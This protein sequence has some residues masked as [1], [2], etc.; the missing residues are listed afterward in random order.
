[1]VDA[2]VQ[3]TL[4]IVCERT[5]RES[6][7]CLESVRDSVALRYSWGVREGRRRKDTGRMGER[8]RERGAEGEAEGQRGR[9]RGEGERKRGRDRGGEEK[10]REGEEEREKGYGQENTNTSAANTQYC[11][12]LHFIHL[13]TC[14]SLCPSSLPPSSLPSPPPPLPPSPSSISPVPTL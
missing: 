5:L 14:S 9:G 1:M 12:V 4:H 2:H 6:A 11:T 10:E 13:T 7:S 8:E 3:C